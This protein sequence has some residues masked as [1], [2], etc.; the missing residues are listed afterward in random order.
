MPAYA[1][2]VFATRLGSKSALAST[3]TDGIVRIWNTS[4]RKLIRKLPS[5]NRRG[6]CVAYSPDGAL[7][8]EVQN[9]GG[10]RYGGTV[11]AYRA[12]NP[13]SVT[14]RSS[15]GGVVTVPTTP[16]VVDN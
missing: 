10:S 16:F 14:I 6:L 8:G 13:L 5:G 3:S 12:V 9:G 1:G 4:S 11:I 7:I 15:A 2:H